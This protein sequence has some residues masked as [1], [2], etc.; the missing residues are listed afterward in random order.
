MHC[1]CRLVFL[2]RGGAA[3]G[4][5]SDNFFGLK[6]SQKGWFYQK[7]DGRQL[8][9][10]ARQCG[11]RLAWKHTRRL[12]DGEIKWLPEPSKLMEDFAIPMNSLRHFKKEI[13][14][15]LD[16]CWPL[17]NRCLKSRNIQSECRLHRGPVETPILTQFS[18][19]VLGDQRVSIPDVD[20]SRSVR[21]HRRT[22]APVY[23]LFL[24]PPDGRSLG[25][26]QQTSQRMVDWKL[27]WQSKRLV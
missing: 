17:I 20:R 6:R 25:K 16:A 15:G 14:L 2:G 18:A 8:I 9:N 1:V 3:L 21:A 26:W 23:F 24:L 12:S 22:V 5:F 27:P 4:P 7:S 10:G 11:I 13:L 19:K